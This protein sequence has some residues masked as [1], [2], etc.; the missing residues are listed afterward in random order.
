MATL[1]DARQ[2]FYLCNQRRGSAL[3]WGKLITLFSEPL[4]QDK[5]KLTP[6]SSHSCAL[7]FAL[8]VLYL[9]QHNAICGTVFNSTSD[10]QKEKI[11]FA[12]CTALANPLKS[13]KRREDLGDGNAL[14]W[15]SD[16]VSGTSEVSLSLSCVFPLSLAVCSLIKCQWGNS[17]DLW[18][19]WGSFC[20]SWGPNCVVDKT[21][22]GWELAASWV[23]SFCSPVLCL[24]IHQLYRCW[25]PLAVLLWIASVVVLSSIL[26]LA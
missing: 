12:K 5:R 11:C 21:H 9:S 17:N 3:R 14:C 2:G 7:C 1:F 6:Q 26:C 23:A 13:P 20:R 18:L 24:Y 16:L 22:S 15:D 10:I 4:K 8:S 19:L 25:R